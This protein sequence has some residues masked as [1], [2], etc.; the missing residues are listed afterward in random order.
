MATLYIA[1]YAA[2]PVMSGGVPQIAPEPALRDQTVAISGS[3]AQSS[4]FGGDT[5]YIGV[6]C[7]GIWSRK[8][9]PNPT[10]LLT[11]FRLAADVIMFYAVQPG[12]KIAG[13][14]NT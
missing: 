1:E 2:L 12:D 9:G 6:T 5:H 3:S 11:S 4:A 8:V 7:D 13:I 10:A 14:T